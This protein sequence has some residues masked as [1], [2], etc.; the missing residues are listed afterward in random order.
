LA[1]SAGAKA[2]DDWESVVAV[3][4][5]TVRVHWVSPT[6]LSAAAR[7]A[8][9][10]TVGPPMAFS[11]LRQNRVT[12]AFS[13]DIYLPRRPTRVNDE[14]TASLGHEMAHC[15]GFAHDRRKR[16]REAGESEDD[17]SAEPEVIALDKQTE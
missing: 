12:G 16:E 3:S 10:R 2:A 13:C 8:G 17:P 9:R 5:V 15:V 1:L 14:P 6:E 11:V 7:S 4:E